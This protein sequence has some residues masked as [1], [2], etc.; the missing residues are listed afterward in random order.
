MQR[1]QKRRFVRNEHNDEIGRIEQSLVLLATQFDDVLPHRSDVRCK[2][3][4]PGRLVLGPDVSDECR[5]RH[6]RV[7]NDP[8]AFGQIKH[9]VGPQVVSR[10][11]LDI[12]LR[13]V[14]YAPDQVR[15]V[16]DRFEDHL[17]PVALHFGI[18][19]ERVGQVGRFGGDAAIEFHQPFEL[20]AQRPPLFVLGGV[21]LLDPLA[22]LHDVIPERFQ[23]HVERFAVGFL[24]SARLFA[25]N[26][27]GEVLEL[28]PESF[29]H[30]FAFGTCLGHSLFGR[31]QTGLRQRTPLD[32]GTDFDFGGS[33]FLFGH[34]ARLLG[35]AAS[36]VR[37]GPFVRQTGVI[38]TQGEQKQ[39]QHDANDAERQ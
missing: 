23:Q 8:F 31:L 25:Q 19:L 2:I 36:F 12:E 7:D 24:E 33:G 37:S 16:E 26:V 18:A 35:Q 4:A 13:I 30:L 21:D 9:H 10:F 28:G 38:P 34:P 27:I 3:L 5:E 17:A 22:E 1:R 39:A 29:L 6:L 32:Q 20:V 14:M 15:I 11:V